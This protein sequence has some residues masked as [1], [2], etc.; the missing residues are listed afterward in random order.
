MARP[1][2]APRVLNWLEAESAFRLIFRRISDR[3]LSPFIRCIEAALIDFD[4]VV[5]FRKR[6]VI[7]S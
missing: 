7:G 1:K 3:K 6:K 5:R 2:S 4:A